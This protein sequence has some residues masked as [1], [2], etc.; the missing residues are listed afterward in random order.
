MDFP[1]AVQMPAGMTCQ[2]TV[3]D[4]TNVCVA[5]I[6][7]GAAAGPFGGS[8][9]FTQSPAAKKRAIEHNL[10][11]KRFARSLEQQHK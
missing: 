10:A 8:V 11:K 9:I 6:Q 7:N 3:G 1:M 2:G 5:R 4:A